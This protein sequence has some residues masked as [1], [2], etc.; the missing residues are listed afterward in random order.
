[1]LPE[2]F[3]PNI[4][5]SREVKNGTLIRVGPGQYRTVVSKPSREL[6]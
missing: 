6:A 4:F 1:M 5:L 2:F 3:Q